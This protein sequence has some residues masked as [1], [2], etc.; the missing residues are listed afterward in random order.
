MIR[1]KYSSPIRILRRVRDGGRLVRQMRCEDDLRGA[2]SLAV[3]AQIGVPPELI[4]GHLLPSLV[5][6]LLSPLL[7]LLSISASKTGRS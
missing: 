5:S 3:L 6:D 7:L 2:A 1:L 4:D